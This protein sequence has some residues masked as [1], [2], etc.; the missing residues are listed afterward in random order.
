MKTIAPTQRTSVAWACFLRSSLGILANL[1]EESHGASAFCLSFSST[2][3]NP[4]TQIDAEK[5]AIGRLCRS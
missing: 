5:E 4:Q 3:N 2:M 1:R